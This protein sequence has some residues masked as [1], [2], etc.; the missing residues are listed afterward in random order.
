MPAG[1]TLAASASVVSNSSTS[2]PWPKPTTRMRSPGAACSS[3]CTSITSAWLAP[4]SPQ[5]A[6]SWSRKLE[7][8]ALRDRLRHA[9]QRARQAEMPDPVRRDPGLVHQRF[10][11]GRHDLQIAFVADP[12]LL[13]NVI[14][15]AAMAAIMV[16]EI[17]RSRM[18]RDE[19]GDAVG[20]P[21]QHRRAAVA[22]RKLERAC[23]GGAA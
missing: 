10:D 20:P 1:R 2:Q 7:T 13:P 9:R 19:L 17:D 4:V 6:A 21:E 11:R 5:P 22:A 12:A 15:L 16:D 23:G 18:L 14:E 8:Q 3:A